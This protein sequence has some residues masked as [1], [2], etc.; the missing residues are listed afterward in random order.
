MWAF[1]KTQI[2]LKVSQ[3]S[4]STLAAFVVAMLVRKQEELSKTMYEHLALG[5]SDDSEERKRYIGALYV[6]EGDTNI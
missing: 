2:R 1:Q 4:T 6:E 5:V 3:M